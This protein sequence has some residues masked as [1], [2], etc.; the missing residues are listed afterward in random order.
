MGVELRRGVAFNRPRGVVLKGSRNEFACC[1]RR[2]DVADPRLGVAFQLGQ[3]DTHTFPMRLS[4]TPIAADKCG[5]RNRLRR[6]ERSISTGA[7]LYARHFLAEF[8]LIGFRNL[9]ANE[10]IFR[11]RVLAFGQP[12]E[13]LIANRAF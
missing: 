13:V 6:G 5:E 3:G 9:M 7:V 11:V 2:V 1:L 10:L 12:S 4:H 8:A